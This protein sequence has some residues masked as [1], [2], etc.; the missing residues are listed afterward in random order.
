M[1]VVCSE[2]EGGGG[3]CVAPVQQS[4]LAGAGPVPQATQQVLPAHQRFFGIVVFTVYS[5]CAVN[6]HR[7]HLN[8]LPN[9][10]L[11]NKEAH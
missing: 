10:Q 6:F 11:K 7:R 9:W 1:I 5:K 2:R 8:W 3:H 4:Q